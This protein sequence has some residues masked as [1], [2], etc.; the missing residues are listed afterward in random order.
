MS[1]HLTDCEA[2]WHRQ[3][4]QW[5]I[6]QSPPPW[7]MDAVHKPITIPKAQELE[8]D[9]GNIES[10]YQFLSTDAPWFTVLHAVLCLCV[11]QSGIIYM[12]AFD[13]ED[14]RSY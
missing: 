10:I 2:K 5:F 3:A 8:N 14:G 4:R 6:Q 11:E 7:F 1:L 9:S 13:C 12:L